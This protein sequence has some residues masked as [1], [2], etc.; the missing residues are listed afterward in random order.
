MNRKLPIVRVGSFE[1]YPADCL[2]EYTG[3]EQTIVAT[4]A[5]ERQRR[6]DGWIAA[7]YLTG[8]EFAF[9]SYWEA[10]DRSPAAWHAQRIRARQGDRRILSSHLYAEGRSRKELL[11]KLSGT[12]LP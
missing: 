2:T 11:E 9:V 8:N 3:T 5:D 7:H 12:R 10:T 1:L 4:P 6:C